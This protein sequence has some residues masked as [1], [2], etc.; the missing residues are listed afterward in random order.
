[1]P[2]HVDRDKKRP[3]QSGVWVSW[4][5]EAYSQV[6]PDLPGEGPERPDGEVFPEALRV[7]WGSQ[8]SP[9]PQ[10]PDSLSNTES[11]SRF[12]P[13]LGDKQTRQA[14]CHSGGSGTL[15]PNTGECTYP[16]TGDQQ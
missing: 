11:S 5:Q 16:L 9:Q 6:V 4:R 12:Q 14:A 15:V 3:R 8:V 10:E 13:D 7:G 1:M 2:A